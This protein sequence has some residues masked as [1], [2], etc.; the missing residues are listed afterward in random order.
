MSVQFQ[1]VSSHSSGH[2]L[3][4]STKTSVSGEEMHILVAPEAVTSV[5]C[6]NGFV[7]TSSWL[8]SGWLTSF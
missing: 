2:L 8:L 5:A 7:S 1:D 3:R 4:A 6:N